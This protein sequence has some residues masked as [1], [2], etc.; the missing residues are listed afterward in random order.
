MREARG[1]LKREGQE[2]R[3]IK[4]VL[5]V[6]RFQRVRERFALRFIPDEHLADEKRGVH[7]VLVTHKAAAQIAV[8]LLK[9]ENVP[10]GFPGLFEKPDL[11]ADVFKPGQNVSQLH[12]VMRGDLL[13]HRRRHNGF[14]RDRPLR[15]RAVC[16][17]HPADKV[18]QQ[19]AHLV[20]RDEPV[21]LRGF[22]RRADTVAVRVRSEQKLAAR[23]FRQTQTDRERLADLRV[24]AGARR[25]IPVRLRLLR[26]EKNAGKAV[27]AQAARHAGNARSV[28]RRVNDDRAARGILRQERRG[29]YRGEIPLHGILA[30]I[31]DHAGSETFGKIKRA[32]V[33]KGIDAVDLRLNR[34]GGLRRDLAAVGAVDLVAVVFGGVVACRD[35]NAAARAKIAHRERERGRRHQAGI[36]VH[37]NAVCGKNTRRGLGKEPGV[38]AAVISDGDGGGGKMRLEI[39][40][41]ALRGLADGENIHAVCAGADHAAQSAGTE[42]QLA[43]KAVL[44]GGVVAADGFQL[45]AE[46]SVSGGLF[47]PQAVQR[48]Y[49]HRNILPN[50]FL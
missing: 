27:R 34:C 28:Q 25:K 35:D 12:A 24:G 6:Q 33:R 31:G 44:D 10:A 39:I 45:F 47:P 32:D 20:A 22:Y 48:V 30:D 49:I 1:T 50:S 3:F 17:A 16:P 43:V 23:L 4:A 41:I 5:C 11:F 14:D 40:G 29:R 7:R 13:R 2:L 8:A 9:A 42:F 18:E 15:H 36:N 26:W 37:A 21:A 38:D 46:R 19:H